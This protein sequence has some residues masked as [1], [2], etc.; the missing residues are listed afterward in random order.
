LESKIVCKA[1]IL[2]RVTELTIN[3]KKLVTPTYFPAISSYGIKHPFQSLFQLLTAYSYPRILFSAYDFHFLNREDKKQLLLEMSRYSQQGGFVYVDS[4]IFESF[5]RADSQWTY[6]LYKSSISEM[7][8]DFYSSFDVLPGVNDAEYEKE[9]FERISASRGLS[10]KAE[11]VPIL[12]GIDS[13][14]LVSL[15]EKFMRL[16]PN[17][18]TVI[19][20]PERDCGDDIVEKA[21]TVMKIRN[22]LD[23]H[24]GN[25]V[26]HILGCGN[27]VSLLLLSYSGADSFDSL[28][29]IKYVINKKDLTTNDFS[30]LELTNCGCAFCSDMTRGYTEKVLLHNLHFYQDFMVQIQSLI[31]TGEIAKFSQKLVGKDIFE[32]MSRTGMLP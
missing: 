6:D 10:T 24:E 29:W 28:D 16:F 15:T 26:L 17:I 21:R 12:H 13:D 27:P 23:D 19:A 32:K 20:V 9:T 31:R 30:H 7:D 18:S 11:F 5:W 14:R 3:G 2:S 25:K 8:F 22:L 1:E 4:G